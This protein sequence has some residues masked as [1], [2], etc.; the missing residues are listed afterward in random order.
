MKLENMAALIE[1]RNL[2]KWFA[3]GMGRLR[4]GLMWKFQPGCSC[5]P[6]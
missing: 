1:L 5:Y 3:V 4:T 2:G 6:G